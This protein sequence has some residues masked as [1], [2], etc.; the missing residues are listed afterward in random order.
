VV[1]VEVAEQRDLGAVVQDL[2]ILPPHDRRKVSSAS[3]PY[4]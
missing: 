1:N 4:G 2:L 3:L